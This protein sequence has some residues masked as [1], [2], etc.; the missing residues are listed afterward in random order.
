[1]M[2]RGFTMWN[3]TNR[4]P[5]PKSTER[6]NQLHSENLMPPAWRPFFIASNENS[7]INLTQ[8][9]H[10]APLCDPGDWGH[11]PQQAEQAILYRIALLA[12]IIWSCFMGLRRLYHSVIDSLDFPFRSVYLKGKPLRNGGDAQLP[13]L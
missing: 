11:R 8:T 10:R 9:S 5:V 1:M 4:M 3:K 13:A 2:N 7:M 6:K 12:S